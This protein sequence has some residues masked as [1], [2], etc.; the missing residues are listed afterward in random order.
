MS[1]DCH[2]TFLFVIWVS[3]I[4]VHVQITGDMQKLWNSWDGVKRQMRVHPSDYDPYQERRQWGTL[5]RRVWYWTRSLWSN[6][7]LKVFQFYFP[8]KSKHNAIQYFFEKY[9]FEY[10]KVF[11]KSIF[12]WIILSELKE[13]FL[14]YFA[15]FLPQDFMSKYTQPSIFIR[16]I[17]PNLNISIYIAARNCITF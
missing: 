1:L 5:V 9:F 6:H 15:Y 7:T 13:H 4:L 17:C 10:I 3:S 8:N 14:P 16:T 12:L 11:Q 2:G